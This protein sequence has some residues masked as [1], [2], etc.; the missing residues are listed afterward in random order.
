MLFR[1]TNER[2]INRWPRC[3]ARILDLCWQMILVMPLMAVLLSGSFVSTTSTPVFTSLTFLL[4]LPIALLIDAIIAGVFGNTPAKAIIGISV[5][6]SKGTKLGLPEHIQ[7]NFGV[8]TAGLSMG[9]LPL[10]VFSAIK[11]FKQ[12]SGRRPAT[13][14]VLL[15]AQVFAT[16]N[17]DFRAA[18]FCFVLLASPLLLSPLLNRN[19]TDESALVATTTNTTTEIPEKDTEA[20]EMQTA[21]VNSNE[22][23]VTA[24]RN[25][26]ET[27]PVTTSADATAQA[28]L[29]E[30]AAANNELKPAESSA[31]A[32]TVDTDASVKEVTL[33]LA[34]TI[35]TSSTQTTQTEEPYFWVNPASGLSTQIHQN[36]EITTESSSNASS[37][38][39]ASFT[40]KPSNTVIDFTKQVQRAL[41]NAS[42]ASGITNQFP[43]VTLSD[44][45]FE[46]ELA[47][48][49]VRETSGRDAVSNFPVSFQVSDV[50]NQ[51]FV[52]AVNGALLAHHQN[53]IDGLRAAIWTSLSI[54][55]DSPSTF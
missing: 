41:D 36:F 5:A 23:V 19:S 20:P 45:W 33:A 4:S 1:K 28:A 34:P 30:P 32:T 26:E 53:E 44:N 52:L 46:F 8:W 40:H 55:P 29:Q 31:V 14:D 18:G 22:T 21:A 16:P 39:I 35:S 11:Q 43:Q 17:S 42:L 15:P 2:L 50:D 25:T 38:L 10:T 51:V 48:L 37:S 7:R 54:D 3:L 24:T 9:V 47:G 13:Y 27:L 12:V 49:Q 6:S